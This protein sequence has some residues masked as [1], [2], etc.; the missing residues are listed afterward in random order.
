MRWPRRRPPAKPPRRPAPAESERLSSYPFVSG[1]T[2]R[3]TADHVVDGDAGVE[4]LPH[5]GAVGADDV[6][7]VE[8][9]FLATAD[10]SAALV[11]WLDRCADAAGGPPRLVLH[12]GDRRPPDDELALLAA[13]ADGVWCV[14]APDGVPGVTPIPIGLENVHHAVNGVLGEFLAAH[15]DPALRTAPRGRPLLA[16]FRSA[17]NPT[18]REPLARAAAASRH[19]F[20]GADMS[21]AQHRAELRRTALVLSPPGNGA[22]CHRTW[23]AM[24]LGAVPVVLR[25][26]VAPS[27]VDTLPV[28]QLDRIEDVLD[29][30][31]GEIAEVHAALSGRPLGRALMPFWILDLNR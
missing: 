3:L 23:E 17:T 22:D 15:R 30:T 21:P 8:V 16:S 5:P 20:A 26:S 25:G 6:V 7:F 9:P 11:T 19:G 1:D 27:L 4:D 12:N 10:R 13:H 18:V 14:N 29:L 2:F 24:L 31:D 28:L